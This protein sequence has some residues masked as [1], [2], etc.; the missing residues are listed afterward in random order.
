M[1]VYIVN[2]EINEVVDGNVNFYEGELKLICY[3]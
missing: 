1:D 2:E 3:I